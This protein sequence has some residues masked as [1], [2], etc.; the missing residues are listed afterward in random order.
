M[1]ATIQTTTI[2]TGPVLPLPALGITPLKAMSRK[3]ILVVDD[4]VVIQKTLSMKLK[5]KGYDVLIAADGGEAVTA[6][7]TQT[8]DLVLLDISFPPDVA[9]GG[10]A[11]WDGFLIM[12]WI[13][14]IEGPAHVPLI[15]LT[16]AD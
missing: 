6:I 7:R 3:K 10:A 9:H 12:D 11:A 1:N 5:I 15:I 4:N 16:R 13:R 8:P 2:S 14:R